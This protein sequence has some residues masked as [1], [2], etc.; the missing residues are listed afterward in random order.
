M[1]KL[2]GMGGKSKLKA[3]DGDQGNAQ[4]DPGRGGGGVV[5]GVANAKMHSECL[6]SQSTFL[7]FSGVTCSMASHRDW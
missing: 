5:E 6:T 2:K 4:E 1:Q 3:R 7:K